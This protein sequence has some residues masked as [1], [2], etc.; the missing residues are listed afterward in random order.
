MS[1]QRQTGRVPKELENMKEMPEI[2]L[3]LWKDFRA[4]DSDRTSTGYSPNPIGYEKIL[5]YY[6]LMKLDI[7]PWEV[8]VLKYFDNTLL[9]CY[10]EQA[11]KDRSTK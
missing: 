7:Q 2:F 9:N 6:K 8:E 4:L 1:V 10:A 5:A 11:E 3:L